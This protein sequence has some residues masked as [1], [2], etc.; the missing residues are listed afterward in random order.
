MD[1]DFFLTYFY[2]NHLKIS[3]HIKLES[4]MQNENIIFHTI[5]KIKG[6]MTTKV[7][8]VYI[9]YR[10]CLD[11]SDFGKHLVSLY[12]KKKQIRI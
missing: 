4:L 9:Y 5:S 2:I 12:L 11:Y 6:K 7:I 10:L 1:I 3:Q 8:F